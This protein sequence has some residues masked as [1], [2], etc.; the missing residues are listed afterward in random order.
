MYPLESNLAS[1]SPE[2]RQF[3]R[4]CYGTLFAVFAAMFVLVAVIAAATPE[5]GNQVAGATVLAHSAV[6]VHPTPVSIHP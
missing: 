4:R 5:T 3:V 2:D 1:L 6:A